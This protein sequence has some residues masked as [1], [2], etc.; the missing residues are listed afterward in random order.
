M[1]PRPLLCLK[2][3][4]GFQAVRGEDG[5]AVEF[6]NRKVAQLLAYLALSPGE[7]IDR[8]RVAKAVW[9][10]GTSEAALSSLR[11][12]LALLR[13]DL[14]RHGLP[15]DELLQAD[16]VSLAVVPGKVAT[17]LADFSRARA[18]EALAAYA[19]PLVPEWDADWAVEARA[20]TRAHAAAEAAQA[21]AEAVAAAHS[22]DPEDE[23][24][25]QAALAA[26]LAD[27]Q[28]SRAVE[29]ARRFARSLRRRTGLVP[30]EA[31]AALARRARL[32]ARSRG[33]RPES[34]LPRPL[35]PLFGRDTELEA[36]SQA[37][38]TP[39]VRVVTLLG[40]GGVGKT[41]LALEAA[42]RERAALQ[43]AV[44]FVDLAALTDPAQVP[45][46]VLAAVAP[47]RDASDARAALV[48]ALAEVPSLLVLDN[49]EQFG[50]GLRS[51]V[52]D[53][54]AALPLTQVLATSR[55]DPRVEGSRVVRLEP[56]AL[57]GPVGDP[58][59]SP[60]VALY[61]ERARS[62]APSFVP[63]DPPTL[64]LLAARLEGLPLA[65]CLAAAQADVL[66]PG[67]TLRQ[68]DDRFALL[69]TET[70]PWPDRH[71]R[72]WAC[73]DWS[74]RMVPESHQL[75]ARFTPFRGGWTLETASSLCPDEPVPSRLQGLLRT[76]LIA[77]S[78]RVGQVRFDM[79]E[80]VREFIEA[81]MSP[82]EREE[83]RRGHA[84]A[85]L[86]WLSQPGRSQQTFNAGYLRDRT[87]EYENLRAA[88]EWCLAHDPAGALQVVNALAYYW[89]SREM[90]R[91]GL[92]WI[93]R[94]LA[95][96]DGLD[97]V[98]IAM[99]HRARSTMLIGLARF[100]EAVSALERALAV[101]PTDADALTQARTLNSLGNALM[102][103][104]RFDEALAHFQ[105][106]WETC[107]LAGAAATGLSMRGNAGLCLYLA[108]RLDEA[109]TTTEAVVAALQQGDNHDWLSYFLHNLG[110]I[111]RAQGD[112]E[113]A[114]RRFAEAR[115]VAE[116]V[117]ND[118]A[119][120]G[121]LVDAAV[122]AVRTG[123]LAQA[124]AW[125]HQGARAIRSTKGAE[126]HAECLEAAAHLFEAEGDLE[127]AA[128]LLGF[129]VEGGLSPQRS[130]A[131]RSPHPAERLDRLRQG[132]GPAFARAVGRYRG[133]GLAELLD[134]VAE[135]TAP[136]D[137]P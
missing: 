116:E 92:E 83:A 36:V 32:S 105:R 77:E 121:W 63:D 34:N 17:D 2:L 100:D 119:G 109:R 99:A 49:L 111:A 39:G 24:L 11:N 114:L 56:L 72:L 25:L 91:E 61:V 28:A 95:Q 62:V 12:A 79:A 70:L 127:E 59:A 8:A 55:T 71:R 10:G 78:S 102:R 134:E 43:G 13:R 23:P 129:L 86:A 45:R 126:Q 130:R 98:P 16:R 21:D 93:D 18:G 82:G 110:L 85:M 68:L 1:D 29:V 65:I 131:D 124:R 40:T 3:L 76:C 132:L 53:L 33:A 133:L 47:D 108:G 104:G 57:P 87:Q 66:S 6:A 103:V 52:E 41:R 26:L 31:T 90:A 54:V 137:S 118:P 20:R 81:Q 88:F 101:L 80:S 38:A 42:E 96:A 48:E 64:G 51:V 84:A 4:G 46:G 30:S 5:A 89:L 106:A 50:P 37:L 67:E 73:L 14:E 60:S 125:V 115:R 69:Q 123:D 120:R 128:A 27:G 97:P 35:A 74:H 15:P 113:G 44:W 112:D 7:R 107:E 135:A 19:G 58:L 117:G 136:A 22:R 94:A 122:S 75:L 9:P